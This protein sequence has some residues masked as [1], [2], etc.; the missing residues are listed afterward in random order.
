MMARFSLFGLCT[1]VLVATFP[2]AAGAQGLEAA[3]R[4]AAALVEQGRHAAAIDALNEAIDQVWDAAP[5]TFRKTLFVT[6]KPA[7]YGV[8]D[9]RAGNEFK[10]G[11]KL[12]VYAEPV[13]Y[14][15]RREGAFNVV[16][17]SVDV[18][19]STAA[20]KVLGGQDGFTRF[21]LRSRV[22]NKEFYFFITYN[23][24]G[25]AP[26]DYIAKTTINDRAGGKSAAFSLPFTITQ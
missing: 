10:P 14:G 25:L 5:L 26:G 1:L 24:S 4:R 11:E 19:V 7:G 2:L 23:F 21:G 18:Q 6:A 16:D 15:F 17:I 3:A 20:G 22:R 9:A 8:Y 12:L 13:G